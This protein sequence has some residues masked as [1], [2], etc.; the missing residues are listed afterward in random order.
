L[1]TEFN[2]GKKIIGNKNPIFIIA[3]IGI[4]HNGNLEFAKK[5]I[6]VAE[7]AGADAVKF[8]S[9]I[10][11]NLVT[12]T[13]KAALYQQNS[14]T[15]LKQIKILEKAELGFDELKILKSYS[16][17]KGLIFLS[18][19][20]DL[21]SLKFLKKLDLDAYKISSGDLTNPILLNEIARIGKPILLSSGMA[22]IEEIKES[23]QWINENG[24]KNIGIMQCTSCYPTKQKDS[25]LNVITTLKNSFNIPIGFSDHTLNSLSAIVSVGLGVDFIEKHITLDNSMNGPD[26]KMSM[27]P[28]DFQKYVELIRNAEQC[29][30]N[31]I[32][33]TLSC[34]EEIKKIARKSIVSKKFLSKNHIVTKN[35]LDVKR[36]GT[37]ILPKFFNDLL[38]KKTKKNLESDTVLNWDDFEN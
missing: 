30:G 32:K 13:A 5:L 34:E 9:F 7:T 22:N 6:D 29:L 16:E 17:N 37:G 20:F 27:N 11:K 26:H 31:E 8:Q 12:S 21:D 28:N 15:N 2:I 19:P 36:P 33:Q 10:A 23:L 25:N 35:D 1:L 24:C 4:N 38:G 14:D 18:T 3:E